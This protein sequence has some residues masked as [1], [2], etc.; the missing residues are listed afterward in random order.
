M[1]TFSLPSRLTGASSRVSLQSSSRA[2]HRDQL[3]ANSCRLPPRTLSRSR[4]N[5]LTWL[6]LPDALIW[7]ASRGETT[8]KRRGGRPQAL[9][10]KQFY[11]SFFLPFFSILKPAQSWEVWKCD[12]ATSGAMSERQKKSRLAESHAVVNKFSSVNRCELSVV[13]KRE[14]WRLQLRLQLHF[15]S[16]VLHLTSVEV[17]IQITLCTNY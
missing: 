13:W 6:L 5:W 16:S 14:Q 4:R 1:W 8:E 17:L 10:C 2:P 3:E 15:Y 12:G 7:S 9:Q 11:F